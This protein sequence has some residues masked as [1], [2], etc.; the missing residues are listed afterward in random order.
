MSLLARVKNSTMIL[1]APSTSIFAASRARSWQFAAI[2]GVFSCF[3]AKVKTRSA[4]GFK[5]KM[6]SDEAISASIASGPKN[7]D[8]DYRHN[9]G[10]NLEGIVEQLYRTS[11][12]C[13]LANTVPK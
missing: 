10:V 5:P 11:G 12:G 1:F 13:I 7:D 6:N 8:R 2:A 4:I 9:D 3:G